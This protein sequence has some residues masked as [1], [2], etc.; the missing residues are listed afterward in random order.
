ME[1]S[2]GAARAPSEPRGHN[3]KVDCE[4]VGHA[5]G[6]DEEMPCGVEEGAMVESEEDD[7]Q[8]VSDAACTK[9]KK[10]VPAN[11]MEKRSNDEDSEPAL[12]QINQGR[13]H[14]ETTDGKALEDD[15]RHSQRPNQAEEN[16]SHWPAQRDESEG[17][18]GCCDEHING[19]V[20]EDMEYVASAGATQRVVE[21]GAEI[22]EYER[23]GKDRAT[24]DGQRRAARRGRD[25][26]DS[27]YQCETKADAVRD[28]V[29][30]KIAQVRT[31]GHR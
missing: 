23:D 7:A 22:D 1:V 19:G 14:G 28:G 6:E 9:P 5:A 24:D 25:E 3:V 17:R 30:E 10:P 2:A 4:V 18:V 13:C 8:G 27:A 29:G 11:G 16:P 15:A 31:G 21:R 20:I 12:K 26:A